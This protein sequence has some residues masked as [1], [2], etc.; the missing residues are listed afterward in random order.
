MPYQ[1]GITW[2]GNLLWGAAGNGNIPA[3]GYRRVDPQLTTSGVRRLTAGSP[4]IN[5][6]SRSYPSVT[7]DVDGLPR[8]GKA[9]V[10][11]DEYSTDVGPSAP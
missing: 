1:Q 11:A 9:D 2:S 8:T 7:R 5:A 4:A 6:A 3:S 10:G